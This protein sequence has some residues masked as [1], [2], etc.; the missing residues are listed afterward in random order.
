MAE[1]KGQFQ[2]GNEAGAK[3]TMEQLTNAMNDALNAA[4]NDADVLCYYDAIQKCAIPYRTIEY[5]ISSLDA[6]ELQSIKKEIMAAIASRINKG[7]LTGGFVPAPAIWRM[8]QLGE[9]D[10]Q[11]IKHSGDADNPV[12]F[13]GIK[14]GE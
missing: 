13:K 5:H 14:F 12:T 6:T 3:W 10:K 9:S 8:K 11:E 7:A 4:K 2:I 1:N